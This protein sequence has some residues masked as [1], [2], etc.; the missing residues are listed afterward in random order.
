MKLYGSASEKRDI[1]LIEQRFVGYEVVDPSAL[2]SD[3]GPGGETEFYLRLV[4]SCD[5]LVF[6]RYFGNVTEGVKPEVD[7]AL[8]KGKPVYEIRD[9]RFISVT[10]PVDNLPMIERLVLRAKGALGIE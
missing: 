8:S 7:H 6:S 10:G 5:C 3:A 9:G 4:D 1:K 2:R